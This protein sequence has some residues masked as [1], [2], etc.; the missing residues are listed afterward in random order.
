MRITWIR[1][2]LSWSVLEAFMCLCACVFC[3]QIADLLHSGTS[4]TIHERWSMIIGFYVSKKCIQL[5]SIS[6]SKTTISEWKMSTFETLI[7]NVATQTGRMWHVTPLLKS[8]TVECLHI[9]KKYYSSK[10]CVKSHEFSK[11]TPCKIN[12]HRLPTCEPRWKMYD[13]SV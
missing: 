2:D 8:R 13:N 5:I 9:L 11:K 1:F 12:R 10:Y 3:W 6:V 4:V 7:C